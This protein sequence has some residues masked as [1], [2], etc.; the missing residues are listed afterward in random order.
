MQC[1]L[2][3]KNGTIVDGTGRSSFK[4]DCRKRWRIIAV[5]SIIHYLIKKM[6]QMYQIIEESFPEG[7]FRLS[8]G[9]GYIRGCMLL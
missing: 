2:S 7:A 4:G 3:I 5:T 6:R 1:D 8:L 9:L